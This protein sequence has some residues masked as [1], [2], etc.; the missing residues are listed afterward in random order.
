MAFLAAAIPDLR[1]PVI[2][3][4]V[5]LYTNTPDEHFLLDRHPDCAAVLVASPCSGHGFKFAPTIGEILADLAMDRAPEFDLAPF[6]LSR[7]AET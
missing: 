6:A 1:G 3:Y 5:C 4:Q 2:E 7:F